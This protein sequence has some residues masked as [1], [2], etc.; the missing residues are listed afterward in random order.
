MSSPSG[1]S[2]VAEYAGGLNRFSLSSYGAELPHI[3]SKLEGARE[4]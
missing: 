2:P 4:L 1:A 3:A